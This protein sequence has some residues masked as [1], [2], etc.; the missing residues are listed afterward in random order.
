MKR[1]RNHTNIENSSLLLLSQTSLQS[2]P[3]SASGGATPR[4]KQRISSNFMMSAFQKLTKC[5]APLQLVQKL[6]ML[7]V[8]FAMLLG[9]I[10]ADARKFQG[11]GDGGDIHTNFI[12]DPKSVASI[13]FRYKALYTSNCKP[14]YKHSLSFILMLTSAV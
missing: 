1:L 13:D 9:Q 5:R 10:V 4:R 6:F 14:F 2:Q 12:S 7:S 3:N 8:C 11:G